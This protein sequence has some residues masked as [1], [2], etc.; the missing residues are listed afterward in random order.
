MSELASPTYGQLL[1]VDHYA[2][3]REEFASGQGVMALQPEM[4]DA[5]L[6]VAIKTV[7]SAANGKP[8]VVFCQPKL[9]FNRVMP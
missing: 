9:R 6:L 1:E 8:F 5:I 3:L 7:I 2:A 4:N